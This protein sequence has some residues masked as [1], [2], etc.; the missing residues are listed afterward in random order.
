M[1]A[2]E[3]KVKPWQ[4]WLGE[5]ELNKTATLE[6]A[7]ACIVSSRVAKFEAIIGNTLVKA[8]KHPEK[9]WCASLKSTYEAV[10]V[11]CNT[12]GVKQPDLKVAAWSVL[13]NVIGPVVMDNAQLPRLVPVDGA[14]SASVGA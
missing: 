2:F 6:H 14:R 3:T 12:W 4:R 7:R 8:A 10:M 9:D 5:S 13:W 1:L 11:D